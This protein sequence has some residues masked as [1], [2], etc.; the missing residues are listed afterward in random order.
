MT[1]VV[2]I[3]G[4]YGRFPWRPCWMAGTMKYLCMKIK[5]IPRGENLYCSNMA[6]KQ[7]FQYDSHEKRKEKKRKKVCN[8]LNLAAH[9]SRK[10]KCG[11]NV[12]VLG[13]Q[14]HDSMW[15]QLPTSL[16]CWVIVIKTPMIL[17]ARSTFRSREPSERFVHSI[18]KISR[19]YDYQTWWTHFLEIREVRKG[20]WAIF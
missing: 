10:S 9:A 16:N 13:A 14:S 19:F 1:S 5:K 3:L 18:V 20:L 4:W 2:P 11:I 7:T 15:S 8:W 6:A 17:C 12:S